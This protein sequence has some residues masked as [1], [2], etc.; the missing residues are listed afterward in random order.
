M[1]WSAATSIVT[2]NVQIFHNNIVKLRKCRKSC[3]YFFFLWDFILQSNNQSKIFLY[4]ASSSWFFHKTEECL[5]HYSLRYNSDHIVWNL[6][7]SFTCFCLWWS[8]LSGTNRSKH[9]NL[10]KVNTIHSFGNKFFTSYYYERSFEVSLN[11]F[12]HST[13]HDKASVFIIIFLNCTFKLIKFLI[14]NHSCITWIHKWKTVSKCLNIFIYIYC[15]FVF[16]WKMKS[17]FKTNT[18][19]YRI[20]SIQLQLLT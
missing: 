18:L 16:W 14:N 10:I 8:K 9:F 2:T 20:I 3:R 15:F 7:K 1:Q 5:L 12:K 11:W 19:I 6:W 4:T 13:K 17:M